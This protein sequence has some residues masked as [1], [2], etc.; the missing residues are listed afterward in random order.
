M[1]WSLRGYPIKLER[2]DAICHVQLLSPNA[3]NGV[4]FSTLVSTYR[5][6]TFLGYNGKDSNSLQ[7]SKSNAAKIYGYGC[8]LKFCIFLSHVPIY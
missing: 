4:T 1:L 8:L 3:I 2:Y 7:L 6:V 5:N